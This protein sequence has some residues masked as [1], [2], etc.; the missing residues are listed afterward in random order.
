MYQNLKTNEIEEQ[1]GTDRICGLISDIGWLYDKDENRIQVVFKSNA[2]GGTSVITCVAD[3]LKD[4][5][6]ISSSVGIKAQ[7]ESEMLKLLNFINK[8]RIYY[9]RF[10]LYDDDTIWYDYTVD[11]NP[12]SIT[13]EQ[14]Y[15]AF[16]IA[17]NCCEH[18]CNAIINVAT[19]VKTADEVIKIIE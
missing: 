1:T 3:I 19:G 15:R 2:V 10:V 9:G 4:K 8:S 11:V 17:D 6:F 5:I 12:S 7:N 13:K 16:S 14:I 18:F